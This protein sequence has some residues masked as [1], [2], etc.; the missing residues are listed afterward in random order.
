MGEG[1]QPSAL[2]KKKKIK[3]HTLIPAIHFQI[4]SASYAFS[5]ACLPEY[6]S[7]SLDKNTAFGFLWE[8]SVRCCEIWDPNDMEPDLPTQRQLTVCN[9]HAWN[10]S[11]QIYLKKC[12]SKSCFNCS[13]TATRWPDTPK[14]VWHSDVAIEALPPSKCKIYCVCIFRFQKNEHYKWM[15]PTA[16]L[17]CLQK[18]NLCCFRIW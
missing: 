15:Y 13:S 10:M 11:S 7:S 14:K 3:S 9:V 12:P 6:H 4:K 17:V 5:A 16:F 2:C 1:C 8:W 18:S